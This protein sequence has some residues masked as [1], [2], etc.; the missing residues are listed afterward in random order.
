M[1]RR[2]GE[3]KFGIVKRIRPLPLLNTNAGEKRIEVGIFRVQPNCLTRGGFR[4]A[5]PSYIVQN[6]SQNIIAV[7]QVGSQMHRCLRL[8]D[9]VMVPF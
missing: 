5:E 1:V 3:A 8:A 4:F 7:G 9:R 6:A 2:E